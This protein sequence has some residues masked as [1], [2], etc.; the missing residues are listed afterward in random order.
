MYLPK[1]LLLLILFYSRVDLY[2]HLV[3]FNF[4]LVKIFSKSAKCAIGAIMCHKCHNAMT[5]CAISHV[6]SYLRLFSS[7]MIADTKIVN[8]GIN[9]DVSVVSHSKETEM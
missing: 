7:K 1:Q 3:S 9:F 5:K 6:S 2:F 8:T 4:I